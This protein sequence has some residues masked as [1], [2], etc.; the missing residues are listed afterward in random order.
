MISVGKIGGSYLLEQAHPQG[1]Q[2]VSTRVLSV[3]CSLIRP[4]DG[5]VCGICLGMVRN[6]IGDFCYFCPI[7][8]L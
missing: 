6:S 4:W 5:N 1:A 2:Y 3:G 8:N 7:W